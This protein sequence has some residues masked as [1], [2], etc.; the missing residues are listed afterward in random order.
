MVLLSTLFFR[1]AGV[2]RWPVLA[3][4]WA[5]LP[6]GNA[7][8]FS[9]VPIRRIAQGEKPLSIRGLMK[10]KVFWLLLAMMVCSGA[11][12]QGM[13][14]WASAFAEAGLG[15]GKEMGDLAG[16]CAFALLMGTA[17]ALYSKYSGRLPLRAAM[18]GSAVL[19]I[20][21]YVTAA[22]SANPVLALIGCALCGFSVGIFWPGTCSTA[23]AALPGGGT[24]MF[25]LMALA[26]DLGCTAG[27]TVVGLAANA[28][29]GR[30]AAGLAVGVVFPLLMLCGVALLGRRGQSG[31]A[32]KKT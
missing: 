27:P 23:V 22:A 20:A 8:L 4:L 14:Q 3:C 29:G 19:C 15:M 18:M 21:C 13:S 2:E 6:L 9:R 28:A 1:M 12:E 25:A 17:R 7:L 30:L 5:L 11:S 16:P 26:G 32:L 24:A 10:Q 31:R